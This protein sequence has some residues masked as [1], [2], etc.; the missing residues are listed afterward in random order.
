M[1]IKQYLAQ[2]RN[3]MIGVRYRTVERKLGKQILK[4]HDGTIR[5]IAD[6]DDAWFAYL[7]KSAHTVFDIGANIGYT[8]LLANVF[9]KPK[10]MVLVDPNPLALSSAATNMIMNGLSANCK[11]I[12]AFVSDKISEKV[13]FYTVGRGAAGSIYPNH[14]KSAMKLNSWY[15]VPTTTIDDLCNTLEVAPDL[16]KI[17]VEGAELMVLEGAR[18]TC[19]LHNSAFMVE[20]HSNADLPMAKNADN[21]LAWC[22]AVGYTM[23][24]LKEGKVLESGNHISHRGRCHV[25]LQPSDRPYPAILSGI[26]ESAELPRE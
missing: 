7:V 18:Q 16:I 22:R 17:D 13:K 19:K 25:L 5:P 10:N 4:V 9:G 8:G 21:I 15:W 23:W 11:F 2:L 14:A 26:Q 12:S 20:L 3:R 6:K 24:Y 1:M